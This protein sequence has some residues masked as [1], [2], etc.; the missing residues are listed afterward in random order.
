[1]LRRREAYWGEDWDSDDSPAFTWDEWPPNPRDPRT[2]DDTDSDNSWVMDPDLEAAPAPLP[3]P[4]PAPTPSPAPAPV[5]ER[6]R[7]APARLGR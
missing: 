4:V 7:S 6:S 1:M 2:G 3:V 5:R